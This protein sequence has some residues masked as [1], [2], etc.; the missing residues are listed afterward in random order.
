MVHVAQ[1]LEFIH[2]ILEFLLTQILFTNAFNSLHISSLPILGHV[3]TAERTT[4]NF[5][6]QNEVFPNG[7]FF[8]HDEV[9]V[10][11]GDHLKGRA[12]YFNPIGAFF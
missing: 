9:S 5:F 10:V 4:P 2:Q 7:S 1:D 11:E 12:L 8:L 3:D 6:Y